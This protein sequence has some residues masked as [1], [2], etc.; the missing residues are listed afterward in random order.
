MVADGVCTLTAGQAGDSYCL[1]AASVT[2]SFT[3]SLPTPVVKEGSRTSLA[4]ITKRFLVTVPKGANV[5]GMV[6]SSSRKH[7]RMS[8]SAVVALKPGLCKL[9]LTIDPKA[10]GKITK[11]V[12]VR[13]AD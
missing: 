13:I 5:S 6:S 11:R 9:T 4:T 12:S 7:C 10:P 8:G 2:R 3:V 1:P